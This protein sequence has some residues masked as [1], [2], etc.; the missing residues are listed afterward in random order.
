MPLP[1]FCVDNNLWNWFIQKF[2]LKFPLCW[3]FSIYLSSIMILVI[4]LL[5]SGFF[6]PFLLFP[7]YKKKCHYALLSN[8]NP[9]PILSIDRG[10]IKM[11][12]YHE[13]SWLSFFCPIVSILLEPTSIPATYDPRQAMPSCAS[14]FCLHCPKVI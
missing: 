5:Y 4:L 2:G 12:I 13:K 11:R 8:V 14:C 9:T 6:F 10:R 3:I 7:F 1:L